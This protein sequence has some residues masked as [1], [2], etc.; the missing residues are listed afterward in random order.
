VVAPT[1]SRASTPPN[2]MSLAI[3]Y[4][5]S[6]SRPDVISHCEMAGRM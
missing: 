6:Q 1:A 5:Q 2:K 3:G 4:P